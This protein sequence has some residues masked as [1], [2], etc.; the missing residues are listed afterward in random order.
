MVDLATITP[1]IALDPLDGRYRAI[2]APLVN[3][4]SEAALNRARLM[5]EVEW[6][7]H[8]T[9]G[10][11]LPGAPVLSEAEKTYLR[12]VVEDFGA[13]DIAELASIEAITRHDVKAVE[14]LLKRRLEAAADAGVAGV[15]G[16]TVLP[17]VGEIVHIFCTSEDINNLAYALTIRSA[18]EEVWLPAARGLV[19]DL[20]A[21]AHQQ[22]QK[23]QAGDA[24]LLQG[25]G[26]P[27]QASPGG[28]RRRR[29]RRRRRPHGA[30]GRG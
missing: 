8:L 3:H 14:Y 23:F 19:A 24:L 15:G 29:G 28:G 1:P 16:P 4:L 18:V 6:L 25:R 2:T 20:S 11:I 27:A 9:E 7:I 22:A 17:G 10:R 26:V 12:G 30:A 13:Q 21:M 5:V